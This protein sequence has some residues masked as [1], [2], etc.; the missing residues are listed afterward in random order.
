MS[1]IKWKLPEEIVDENSARFLHRIYYSGK[2][3]SLN[4]KIKF[5]RTRETADLATKVRADSKRLERTPFHTGIS[6]FNRIPSELRKLTPKKLRNK[7]K[8]MS[9][10]PRKRS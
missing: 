2:P 7:L 9:L 4:N 5:P 10:K 6:N 1:S 3:E 8:K